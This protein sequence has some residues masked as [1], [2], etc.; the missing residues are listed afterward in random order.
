M[1]HL[2]LIS[3]VNGS[4]LNWC[5]QNVLRKPMSEDLLFAKISEQDMTAVNF[6]N[7]FRD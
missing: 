6:N 2:I 7:H 4:T 5:E 1:L 3:V